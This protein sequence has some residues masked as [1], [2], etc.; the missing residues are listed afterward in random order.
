M[1][2]VTMNYLLKKAQKGKYIVGAC[3]FA[4]LSIIQGIFQ[5]AAAKKSSVFIMPFSMTNKEMG[6]EMTA[7]AIE[8]LSRQYISRNRCGN[9]FGSL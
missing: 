2:I 1:S 9:T 5:G 3:N 4:D 7:K 6:I 8:V